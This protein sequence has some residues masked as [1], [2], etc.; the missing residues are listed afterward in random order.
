VS[1]MRGMEAL[2]FESVRSVTLGEFRQLVEERERTG[3]INRYE[4]LSGRVVLNPPEGWPHG[5]V[6][7]ALHMLFA[8]R[9]RDGLVL[10]SRQGFQLPS[11][12]VVQADITFLSH[13]RLRTANPVDGEWLEAVPDLAVEVMSGITAFR[14]SRSSTARN[15]GWPVYA[16]RPWRA[17]TATSPGAWRGC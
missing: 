5:A 3:D 12:D 7:S 17:L 9:S 15:G 10:G 2:G 1:T 16:P 14:A 6:G 13:E 4:L 8:E 11:E